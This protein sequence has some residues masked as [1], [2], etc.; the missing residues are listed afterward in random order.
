MN[1]LIIIGLAFVIYPLFGF[2]IIWMRNVLG[3][4]TK[5]KARLFIPI[6]ISFLIGISILIYAIFLDT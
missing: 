2:M 5:P 3:N 6:G 1:T 4:D